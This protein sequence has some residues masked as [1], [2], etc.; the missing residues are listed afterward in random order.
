MSA[1]AAAAAAAAVRIDRV[2]VV[3]PVRN[4][5]DLL[6]R[7]LNA[8]GRATA[9]LPASTAVSVVLVLDRCTDAS[10]AVAERHPLLQTLAVT[11]GSVGAA[12]HAGVRHLLGA[13]RGAGAG[14][15][16][17]VEGGGIAGA[18][19]TWIATTD[20]DSAVPANWLT[21]QLTFARNGAELVLGTVYPDDALPA[22][23]QDRWAQGHLL[24]DGHP[25]VYG[26]NL[27][28]RADRYLEVG[29]FAS[30]TTDEDVRLVAAL[31]ARGVVE[32]RSV[33]IAVLTSGRLSGRAPH[34]FAG[35]LRD[36]AGA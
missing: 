22:A 5:Q 13:G 23:G 2:A 10:A 12:R 34:G 3:V 1:A 14:A 28:V 33:Q 19:H 16:I 15:R 30:V 32:V 26:A 7:C 36:L 21:A 8:L 11:A 18:A 27:G 4:E 9:A 31:R 25:H 29:G 24:R 17:G 6:P 35:Y 20:A